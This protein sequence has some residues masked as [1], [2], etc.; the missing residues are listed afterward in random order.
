LNPFPVKHNMDCSEQQEQDPSTDVHGL[1]SIPIRPGIEK[2]R[3]SWLSMRT[4]S[5]GLTTFNT[6]L[7]FPSGVFLVLYGELFPLID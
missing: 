7:L 2:P 4:A 1:E 5:T 3:K 6:L